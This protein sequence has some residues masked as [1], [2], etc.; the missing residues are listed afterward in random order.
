LLGAESDEHRAVVGDRSVG[1]VAPED[2]SEA[3]LI[4]AGYVGI[5]SLVLELD[6]VQL[7]PPDDLLLRG[8]RQRLPRGCVVGPLLQEQDRPARAGS[9]LGDEDELG[10]ID[11][12]WILGSVDDSRF[13]R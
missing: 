2:L 3:I 13:R 7:Q 9:S 8:I 6:A 10:R 12:R 4:G 11:Q 5:R 1:H